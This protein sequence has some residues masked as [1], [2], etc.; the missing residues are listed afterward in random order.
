MTTCIPAMDVWNVNTFDAGLRGDLD[1]HADLIRNYFVTS[2]QLWLEREAS[3][4]TMPTPE[5]PYAGEYNWVNEHIM[6]LMEERTIRA[7][8]YT[9]MTDGEVTTLRRDGI[10]ISTLDSIHKRF[11]VQVNAGA[12]S[13]NVADR[14]FADSPF[15]RGQLDARSNK[16]WMVSHPVNT[17]DS[18]VK[19]LLE[20]WGGES[21]YF[22]QRDPDLQAILMRIGRSRILEIAV[23]LAYSRHSYSAAEA[24]VATYA[25]TLG[26]CPDKGA[27]DLYT[28]QPLRAEHIQSIHS[29]GDLAYT[30]I[31]RGYPAEY[32]DLG[33]AGG[34]YE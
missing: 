21:A 8:H 32:I 14:L 6:G 25:R 5:N 18:S 13:Q 10:Y 16:F 26:C 12:F 33:L 23:P 29:Q 4:H 11:A 3:D 20:S 1:V 19:L 30:N 28:H 2:K 7:W 24:V 22:W 31:A 17:E 27:F 9:R 34:C 15:Q